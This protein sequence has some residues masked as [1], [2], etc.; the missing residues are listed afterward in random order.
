MLAR[1]VRLAR[2]VRGLRALRDRRGLSACRV[3]RALLVLGLLGPPAL[4]DRQAQM[5][6]LVR[7]VPRVQLALTQRWLVL[8]DR[9]AQQEQTPPSLDRRE[10]LDLRV[11]L[12]RQDLPDQHS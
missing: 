8:Q 1:L 7:L 6:R 3:L 12:A 2:R 10:R 5:G 11:R 9:P 4:Q